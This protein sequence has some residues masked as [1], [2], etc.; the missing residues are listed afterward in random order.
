MPDNKY[1][2][3]SNAMQRRFQLKAAD[4]QGLNIEPPEYSHPV[5]A[6][7]G[8]TSIAVRINRLAVIGSVGAAAMAVVALG[9]ALPWGTV[10]GPFLTVSKSGLSGDGV[11]TIILAVIGIGFFLVGATAKDGWAFM[12]GAT[13]SVVILAVAIW[14]TVN[15]AG[16]V[17]ESA[18]G[19]AHVS[20]GVGLIVCIIAGAIGLGA[21]IDGLRGT[22]IITSKNQKKYSVTV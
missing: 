8:D 17:S 10:S 9:S 18:S 21:G 1:V 4:L 3:L 14:D 2:V 5:P 12:V 20:V 15:V 7:A 22:V 16:L 19:V 6:R 13:I 11:I